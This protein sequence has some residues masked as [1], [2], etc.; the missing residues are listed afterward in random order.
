[1]PRSITDRPTFPGIWKAVLPTRGRAGPSSRPL[2]SRKPPEAGTPQWMQRNNSGTSEPHSTAER[3]R[4]RVIL[5]LLFPRDNL[6]HHADAKPNVK[7]EADEAFSTVGVRSGQTT[8]ATRA[9]PRRLLTNLGR[10]QYR[11]KNETRKSRQMSHRPD[12]RVVSGS[13]Q[14]P[15][16]LRRKRDRR[17]TRR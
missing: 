10:A 16:L 6:A 3:C 8:V 5:E 9:Q 7:W 4:R 1:M 11:R 2:S 13:F 14:H 15:R 17:D 12:A